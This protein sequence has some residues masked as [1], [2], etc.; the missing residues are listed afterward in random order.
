MNIEEP[1]FNIIHNY[2]RPERNREERH[3]VENDSEVLE[4]EILEPLSTDA[5]V[6]SENGAERFDEDRPE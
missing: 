4:M 1:V 5:T 3:A 6:Q 2:R